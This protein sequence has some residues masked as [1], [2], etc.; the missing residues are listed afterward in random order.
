MR[1]SIPLAITIGLICLLFDTHGRVTIRE[2][3]IAAAI[4]PAK[5]ESLFLRSLF[6]CRPTILSNSAAASSE[7]YC[8]SISSVVISVFIFTTSLI[9]PTSFFLRLTLRLLYWI[10]V[11]R[12]FRRSGQA[13]AHPRCGGSNTRP[14]FCSTAHK[15]TL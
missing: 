1:R 13:K 3:I 15:Q 14:G 8:L 7:R 10:L 2:I 4:P 5:R 9:A 12:F 6:S 11:S